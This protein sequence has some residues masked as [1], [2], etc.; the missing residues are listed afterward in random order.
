MRCGGGATARKAV[1]ETRRGMFLEME[2]D[3]SLDLV[4]AAASTNPNTNSVITG[5][6]EPS[7]SICAPIPPWE[8]SAS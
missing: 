4:H 3:N 6:V 8:G 2:Q 1:N 7:N 5:M